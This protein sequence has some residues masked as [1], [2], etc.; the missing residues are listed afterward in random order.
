[1][2]TTPKTAAELFSAIPTPRDTRERILYTALDLFHAHGFHAVGLDRI[3][4]A[5]GVT[6][7]TF[8]NHF[9]SRDDLIV[10][11]IT[12]RDEWDSAAFERRLH[13]LA[14]YAPRDLLLAM[15]DVLDEWFT[16]ADFRGCIFLHACA[17][18]PSPTDPVH[19]AAAKYYAISE[20]TVAQM[21]AAAGVPNP[22]A[23]AQEWTVLL[24]GAITR[25]MTTGDDQAA[26]VAR[27]VAER[28]LAA[29]VPAG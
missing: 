5:V 22:Q 11:A 19:C 3:L 25:R 9:E 26:R 8:Y 6:K 16:H 2:A 7:T 29:A 23:F 15:F 12:V 20:Q 27:R 28:L 18:F 4:A 10:Q 24:Q 21:A 14:G 1:M 13:E 17:E